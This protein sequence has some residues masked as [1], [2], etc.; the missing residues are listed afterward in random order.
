MT[1]YSNG[2]IDTTVKAIVNLA[3]TLLLVLPIVLLYFLRTSGGVK[4]AI[5]VLFVVSFS[6]ALSTLTKAKRHEVF[7]ATA[8]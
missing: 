7:A 3:A 8:A 1:Y 6:L 5:L 4:I 2:R